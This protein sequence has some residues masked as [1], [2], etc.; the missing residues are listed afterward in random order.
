MEPSEVS[1]I[2]KCSVTTEAQSVS[3]VSHTYIKERKMRSGLKYIFFQLYDQVS[4]GRMD[5]MAF[6]AGSESQAIL[7]C[8]GN[9]V[10]PGLKVSV[11]DLVNQDGQE[12]W[13]SLGFLVT[14]VGGKKISHIIF[15]SFFYF[16]FFFKLS[17]SS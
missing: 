1:T 17:M 16:C 14:L 9:L 10:N 15:C 13:G 11:D 4:M 12:M 6:Q 2:P 8:W 5:G 3:G 7:V